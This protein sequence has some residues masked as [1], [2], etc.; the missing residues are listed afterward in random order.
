MLT[1]LIHNEA[2]QPYPSFSKCEAM[3]LDRIKQIR[4][5][6]DGQKFTA[7][8][9]DIYGN[10]QYAKQGSTYAKKSPYT[11]QRNTGPMVRCH[12]CGSPD[13]LYKQCPDKRYNSSFSS[14]RYSNRNQVPTQSSTDGNMFNNGRSPDPVKKNKPYY[15]PFQKQRNTR[16]KS[17]DA[18][19]WD[20][21][22][23]R[24]FEV[25]SALAHADEMNSQLHAMYFEMGIDPNFDVEEYDPQDDD[26]D[27]VPDN[28]TPDKDYD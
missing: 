24:K 25:Q 23:K 20:N 2:L 8:T 28:I 19:K 4:E 15:G 14:Q 13:H 17:F 22:K 26:P 11:D 1:Q 18:A 3:L 21:V 7:N 16:P 5:S 10:S 27:D 6:D 12:N 9:V